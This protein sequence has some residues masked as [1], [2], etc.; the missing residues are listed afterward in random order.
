MPLNAKQLELP[1]FVP[2]GENVSQ[3]L[4][5]L[6]KAESENNKPKR[7]KDF[8]LFRDRTDHLPWH[9]EGTGRHSGKRSTRTFETEAEAIA[10]AQA[11]LKQ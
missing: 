11:K 1:Y 8:Y 9:W 3:I 4:A 2:S 6:R 5:E 7:D 10:D